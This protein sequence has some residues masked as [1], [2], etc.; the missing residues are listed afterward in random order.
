[1]H[2]AGVVHVGPTRKEEPM[3]EHRTTGRAGANPGDHEL[4]DRL[5]PDI[6]ERAAA[7]I[8][9]ETG[10]SAVLGDPRDEVRSLQQAQ[11]RDADDVVSGFPTGVVSGAQVRGAA[12]WGVVGLLAGAAIGALVGFIPFADLALGTRVI[13]CA[14]VGA[15]VLSTPGFVF[16]GG[17]Q[18]EIEGEVRDASHELSLSV[19]TTND[20]DAERVEQVL[21][22]A[23][24]EVGERAHRLNKQKDH[25]STDA[26]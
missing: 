8:E 14:I 23:D 6:A 15:F 9:R 13:I 21:H 18:P 11:Q 25:N 5:P 16:G 2:S 1:V 4:L 19:H 24:L 26:L 7:R 3:P 20:A 12:F 22:E 17:R 10:A